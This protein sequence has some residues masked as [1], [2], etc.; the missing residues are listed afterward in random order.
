MAITDILGETEILSDIISIA[1]DKGVINQVFEQSKI[2]IHYSVFARVLGNLFKLY[3]QYLDSIDINNVK[4]E[5]LLEQLLKPFVEKQS[6]T[7]SKTILRFKR[8]ESDY[9]EREDILIEMGTRVE[10]EEDNP[11]VFK[12]AEAKVLRKSENEVKVTAYSIDFGSINN[13]KKNTLTYYQSEFFEQIEVTNIIDAYGGKDEETAF[14]ARARLATFRYSR[15]G[16]SS[17]V[18]S[19]IMGIGV[20][21]PDYALSQYYDGSGSFLIALD[22]ES[23]DQYYDIVKQIQMGLFEGLSV[24]FCQVDRVYL[25]LNIDV[26]ITGDH[27]Y[28]S[29]DVA[30]ITQNIKE[31]VEQYF[32]LNIF[33]GFKLSVKRLESFILQYLIQ[34]NYEIYEININVGE[35]ANLVF[36]NETGE[37]VI[38]PYQKFYANKVQTDIIYYKN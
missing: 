33:V 28:N 16:S 30:D 5:A 34:N 26:G 29:Y 15:D 18:N 14:D 25:D 17:Q 24:H 7:L 19:L 38:E 23:S 37:L 31:A 1:Q 36:D 20:G 27:M 32:N 22:V 35:D 8:R 6:S 12:T 10:T 2:Y 9:S 3:T 21:Y 13:V 4:D 11:I